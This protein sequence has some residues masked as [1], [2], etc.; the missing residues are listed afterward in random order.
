MY[1]PRIVYLQNCRERSAEVDA[2]E[3]SSNLDINFVQKILAKIFTHE[4]LH[5]ANQNFVDVKKNVAP[6]LCQQITTEPDMLRP[7]KAL[8]LMDVPKIS[9]FRRHKQ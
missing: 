6:A 1:D 4:F 8:E 3:E 5:K 9:F 7:C 2:R